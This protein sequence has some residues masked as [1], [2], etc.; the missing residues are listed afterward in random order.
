MNIEL[1]AEIRITFACH[2]QPVQ[3][4]LVTLLRHQW[5]LNE[6]ESIASKECKTNSKYDLLVLLDKVWLMMLDRIVVT[7]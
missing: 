6:Q 5:P 4:T 3:G 1:C 2:T 7:T